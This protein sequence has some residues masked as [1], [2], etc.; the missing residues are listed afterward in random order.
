M[1]TR[2]GL[3]KL[4]ISIKGGSAGCD[5]SLEELRLVHKKVFKE[6]LSDRTLKKVMCAHQAAKDEMASEQG[7]AAESRAH[8]VK[9]FG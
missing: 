6:Y 3:G 7:T 5:K 2:H 9:L 4:E 8:F 1:Y